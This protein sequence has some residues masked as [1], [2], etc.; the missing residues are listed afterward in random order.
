MQY[1]QLKWSQ[2]SRVFAPS[3]HY[4]R[5]LACFHYSCTTRQYCVLS[6]QVFS[7]I[8]H[9]TPC[10]LFENKREIWGVF[11]HL[12]KIIWIS[13]AVKTWTPVSSGW[14]DPTLRPEMSSWQSQVCRLFSH[15]CNS[16]FA[17][18]VIAAKIWYFTLNIKT[19]G[20]HGIPVGLSA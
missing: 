8:L 3:S 17:E 18:I 16:I 9:S 19:T 4:L 1:L 10:V 13:C 2:G 12:K 7:K 15:F 11:L 20:W 5:S 6:F 14:P